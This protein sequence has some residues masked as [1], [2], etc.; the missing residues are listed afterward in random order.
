MPIVVSATCATISLAPGESMYGVRFV[1]A[2]TPATLGGAVA[3]FGTTRSGTSISRYRSACLRGFFHSLY[4]EGEFRL[5]KAA[6]L[7]KFWVDSIYHST[8]R[9]KQPIF[10]NLIPKSSWFSLDGTCGKGEVGLWDIL[11]PG[12]YYCRLETEDGGVEVKKMVVVR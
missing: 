5:G 1:R 9:R 11:A 4:E 12:L 7:G 3:F 10:I 8:I 2:G 6:L